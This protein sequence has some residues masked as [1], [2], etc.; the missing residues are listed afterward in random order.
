[1]TLKCLLKVKLPSNSKVHKET[2]N[3]MIQCHCHYPCQT[4]QSLTQHQQ[5]LSVQ[6]ETRTVRMS[7]KDFGLLFPG[8]DENALPPITS[9]DLI[10]PPVTFHQPLYGTI[11]SD[12]RP[13][14][15]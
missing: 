7:K 3:K 6:R 10:S 8:D 2:A 12:Y 9:V 14:H 15:P 5:T 1:M 11:A 4:R 13:N